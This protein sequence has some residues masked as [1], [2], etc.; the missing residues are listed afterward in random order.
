M[1]PLLVFKTQIYMFVKQARRI[2]WVSIL[3][4]PLKNC[5]DKSD[6]YSLHYQRTLNL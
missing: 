6:V 4:A 1:N 3:L 5:V 2:G